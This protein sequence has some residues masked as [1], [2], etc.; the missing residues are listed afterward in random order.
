MFAASISDE[1]L[2]FVVNAQLLTLPSEDNKRRWGV[3]SATSMC[4]LELPGGNGTCSVPHPTALHVLSGC[5]AAL[6]QGRYTWRHNSVLL[7]LKQQF[8]PW[9]S[10][11]NSEKVQLAR[12]TKPLHF[13]RE[14]GTHYR[15][16]CATRQPAPSSLLD[17]LSR[18]TDWEL[19]FD[20]PGNDRFTYSTFPPDIASTSL[21]PDVL[22]ISHQHRFALCLEL[23]CPSEER[24]ATTHELKTN[25]YAE[26][27]ESAKAQ[28]WD[29]SVWPFEV[30][31]RGFVAKS[32]LTM[33]KSFGFQRPQQQLIKQQLEDVARRCS[34]YIFCSRRQAQWD[35]LRPL[36][37]PSG[38]F[39]S[40]EDSDV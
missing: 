27:I 30:G 22:L 9:I 16:G 7:V 1:V 10:L 21:R 2:K 4:R 37:P 8:V 32:T 20:L 40:T 33:L 34:Y 36:L 15:P 38:P 3:A 14:D 26:L 18:A 12:R 39:K 24:I 19:F 35:P 5:K 17:Y 25:K 6:E 13:V 29:L 28:H 11:I 31:C 23:T